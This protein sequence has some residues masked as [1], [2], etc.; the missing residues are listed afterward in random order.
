MRKSLIL[1]SAAAIAALAS[2]P[3]AQARNDA[4]TVF[5]GISAATG[6]IGVFQ[7][8]KMIK[9]N[10]ENLQIQQQRDYREYRRDQAAE[11]AAAQRAAANRRAAAERAA[12]NKRAEE[13]ARLEAA[14]AKAS[15]DAA[16][17]RELDALKYN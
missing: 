7:N 2:V 6:L 9:Q 3:A 16:R 13:Q 5:N 10:N 4:N 1:I 8:G 12:A 17:Q 11:S 15:A 14:Q